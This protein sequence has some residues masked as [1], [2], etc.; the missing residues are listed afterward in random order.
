MTVR[1]PAQGDGGTATPAVSHPLQRLGADEIR[2]ARAVLDDQGLVGE[3]TRF[4]YLGLDEPPKG[5]VL[6]FRPGDPVERRV[7]VVLLDEGSGDA[8]DVVVSLGR[9]AIASHRVL[10]TGREG[11][12]PIML[13]DLM[14]VD[15]IVKGD[16]GWRAAMERT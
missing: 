12:P 14:A 16:D 9:R 1:A 8:A 7:R 13:E 6:A 11:Q 5:E 3:R 2:L 15:E 10:D 4:A